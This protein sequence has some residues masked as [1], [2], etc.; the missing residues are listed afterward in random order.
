M[1]TLVAHAILISVAVGDIEVSS[2]Q[3]ARNGD[4]I[5]FRIPRDGDMKF[6]RTTAVEVSLNDLDARISSFGDWYPTAVNNHVE[7]SVQVVSNASVVVAHTSAS[8]FN[9]TTGYAV[10]LLKQES[11]TLQTDVNA[12]LRLEKEKMVKQLTER[13]DAMQAVLNERLN[14]FQATINDAVNSS[15]TELATMKTA[16]D[17]FNT[18]KDEE[19]KKLNNGSWAGKT[20]KVGV[21]NWCFKWGNGIDNY[22][23]AWKQY[24]GM[25][26]KLASKSG[27]VKITLEGRVY[28]CNHGGFRV[29]GGGQTFGKEPTYG[30]QWMNVENR[31]HNWVPF[32]IVRHVKTTPGQVI[33]YQLQLR[34]QNN[35]CRLHIAGG[36]YAQQ[37]AGLWWSMEE[38]AE[39]QSKP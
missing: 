26:C 38:M 36:S 32:N 35:G 19:L 17:E 1:L 39:P 14:L 7:A 8:I 15:A 28:G 25:N 31:G 33:D 9:T 3:L 27:W 22:N 24:P 29:V 11:V 18:Y 13:I 4:S 16:I 10:P 34:S 37:Y 6:I 5:E 2:P 20:P 21:T 23:S 12:S 30:L